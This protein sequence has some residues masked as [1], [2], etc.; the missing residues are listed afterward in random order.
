MVVASP[1]GAR[2][3]VGVGPLRIVDE[4]HDS[5]QRRWKMNVWIESRAWRRGLTSSVRSG[6]TDDFA[7]RAQAKNP[8][9][10][11]GRRWNWK[12]GRRVER[13]GA[14]KIWKPCWRQTK[15]AGDIV[16][17]AKMKTCSLAAAR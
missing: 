9:R 3:T 4:Q 16:A 10:G 15:P 6:D 2:R 8:A 17:A 12:T 5:A 7:A 14:A 13:A 1:R 11:T